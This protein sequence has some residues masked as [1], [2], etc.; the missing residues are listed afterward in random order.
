MVSVRAWFGGDALAEDEKRRS[1]GLQRWGQAIAGCVMLSLIG[2]VGVA[3]HWLSAFNVLAGG[4]RSGFKRMFNDASDW[5]QD[6]YRVRDWINSHRGGEPIYVRSTFSGHEELRAVGTKSF[7]E[8]YQMVD[9]LP[10][11]CWF[12]VSKSDYAIDAGLEHQLDG[13]PVTEWIGGTHVV[14]FL[15]RGE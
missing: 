13:L 14:Y 11:P 15:E 12:V 9:N 7:K 5:G 10:R 3:P 6:T 2:S 1:I 4:N 8:S